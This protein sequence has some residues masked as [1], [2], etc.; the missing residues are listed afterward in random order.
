MGV[1]VAR[2]NLGKVSA[3]YAERRAN[4]PKGSYND[5]VAQLELLRILEDSAPSIHRANKILD[6]DSEN[7]G[8]TSDAAEQTIDMTRRTD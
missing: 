1:P 8:I 3:R 5:S 2:I 7:N 4:T 6:V